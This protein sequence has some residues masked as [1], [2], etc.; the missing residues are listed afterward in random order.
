MTKDDIKIA[1]A[2]LRKLKNEEIFCIS[3]FGRKLTVLGKDTL[4]TRVYNSVNHRFILAK[5]LPII[6]EITLDPATTVRYVEGNSTVIQSAEV[7]FKSYNPDRDYQP[8]N[9]IVA[10]ASGDNTSNTSNDSNTPSEFMSLSR[11]ERNEKLLAV[12]DNPAK[13]LEFIEK[14]DE[15]IKSYYKNS[16]CLATERNKE[17]LENLGFKFVRD[18]NYSVHKIFLIMQSGVTCLT[19]AEFNALEAANEFLGEFKGL[20]FRAR[21]L[22]VTI[23]SQT[24]QMANTTQGLSRIGPNGSVFTTNR[25]ILSA[26]DC[27]IVKNFARYNQVLIPELVVQADEIAEKAY[28]DKAKKEETLKIQETGA[29]ADEEPSGVIMTTTDLPVQILSGADK[30]DLVD[31][32]CLYYVVAGIFETKEDAK[33]GFRLTEKVEFEN[34]VIV[35]A[36]TTN[37]SKFAITSSAA[38]DIE[39][40]YQKL[41]NS[42]YDR[43]LKA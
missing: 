25:Y 3:K 36:D 2:L 32:I 33:S 39:D 26:N 40:V 38:T 13:T 20:L 18:Y 7:F 35:I 34:K 1:A 30:T 17:I 4:I 6:E 12:S 28:L 27:K 5:H 22:G 42:F 15:Q 11:A 23:I 9:S 21:D 16:Y 41:Y 43:I 14:L 8:R 37:K 29:S 19:S 24:H 10:T 31:I